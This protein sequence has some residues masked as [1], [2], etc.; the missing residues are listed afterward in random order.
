MLWGF[1]AEF[2]HLS[3][4][5]MDLFDSFPEQRE[6]LVTHHGVLPIVEMVEVRSVNVLPQILRVVN[7]VMNDEF[8]Q[9]PTLEY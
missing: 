7:K 3:N 1:D 5:Q 2:L 6:H 8:V 4:C 9:L